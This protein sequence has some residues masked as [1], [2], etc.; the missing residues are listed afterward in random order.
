MRICLAQTSTDFMVI[1]TLANTIWREYYIPIIGKLQVD[2]M[3]KNFQSVNSIKK[4]VTHGMLYFLLKQ[5]DFFVG[6]VAIKEEKD[7]LFL[8]KFY[9]LK[10]FRRMGLGKKTVLFIEKKAKEKHLKNIRLTVNVNNIKAINTYTRLGFVNTAPL[11]TDIGN[12]FIMDDFEM[13][14]RL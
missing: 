11:V 14:K 8:S 13:F 9:I 1:E 10:T 2:Y 5:D 6:Y 7:T 4:E 3:L 12:G